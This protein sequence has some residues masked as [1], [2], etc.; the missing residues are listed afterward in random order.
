M[1]ERTRAA[2]KQQKQTEITASDVLLT[3][4]DMMHRSEKKMGTID[5]EFRRFKEMFGV[6]PQV[7]LQGWMMLA[8]AGLIPAHG[9]LVHWLWALC[10]LKVYAKQGV[11]C[12]LCGGCDPK[13]FR[14]RVWAF[15]EAF[16]LLEAEVVRIPLAQCLRCHKPLRHSNQS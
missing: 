13:T 7:A 6:V 11:M 14:T 15:L 8:T 1:A 3:G 2:A 9:A 16:V 4:R 5:G 10:F 12:V